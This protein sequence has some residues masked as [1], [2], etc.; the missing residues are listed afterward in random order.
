[1]RLR[2]YLTE[3]K[4]PW[5]SLPMKDLKAFRKKC[6]HDWKFKGE[7]LQGTFFECTKCGCEGKQYGK[8][9]VRKVFK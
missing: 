3:E 7:Y 8:D 2:E 9:N 5:R 6:K 4:A 1:M